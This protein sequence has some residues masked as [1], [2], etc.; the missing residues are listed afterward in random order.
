MA[1]KAADKPSMLDLE[2][3]LGCQT[4]ACL[5]TE[6]STASNAGP[7]D[8]QSFPELDSLYFK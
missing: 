7:D 1:I 6:I 5:E 8:S 3:M 2:F 4:K